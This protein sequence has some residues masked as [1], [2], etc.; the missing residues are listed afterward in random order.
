MIGLLYWTQWWGFEVNLSVK[1]LLSVSVSWAYLTSL[2]GVRVTDGWRSWVI[3]LIGL[4]V[5][6]GLALAVLRV[7]M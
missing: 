4:V 3:Y 6:N 1:I 5:L 7:F 2:L